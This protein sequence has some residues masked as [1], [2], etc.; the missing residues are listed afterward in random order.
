MVI[1]G[2]RRTVVGDA[3]SEDR[4]KSRDRWKKPGRLDGEADPGAMGDADA[5][6]R[7]SAGNMVPVLVMAGS[8]L[9]ACRAPPGGRSRRDPGAERRRED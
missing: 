1:R 4:W 5:G 9:L 8:F 7:R 2:E 6:G 3:G